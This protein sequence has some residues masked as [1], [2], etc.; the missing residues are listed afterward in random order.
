[1]GWLWGI[2]ELTFAK[3]LEPCLVQSQC[4]INVNTHKC[5]RS[6]MLMWVVTVGESSSISVHLLKCWLFSFSNLYI[7]FRQSRSL[8]GFK[9]HLHGG[10]RHVYTSP[11]TSLAT[12]LPPLERFTSTSKR[13]WQN[14]ILDSPT[15]MRIFHS[16][17]IQ[18]MAPPF[19]ELFK[20]QT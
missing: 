17:P 4:G 16:S 20:L 3:C 9:D 2:N 10:G 11:L 12:T 8:G 1:M 13:T 7:L 5:L 18:I 19:T 15:P 6:A 14:R